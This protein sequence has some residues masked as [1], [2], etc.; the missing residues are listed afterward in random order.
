LLKTWAGIVAQGIQ[1]QRWR[2]HIQPV[3]SEFG[4]SNSKINE[5]CLR[6]DYCLQLGNKYQ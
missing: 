2:L 6:A 5:E 1:H 3:L 4:D